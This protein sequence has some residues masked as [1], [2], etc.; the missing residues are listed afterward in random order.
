[1]FI[2]RL[3]I[4]TV[5]IINVVIGKTRFTISPCCPLFTDIFRTVSDLVLLGIPIAVQRITLESIICI[6]FE[7]IT[8]KAELS[9]EGRLY[10]QTFTIAFTA[11]NHLCGNDTCRRIGPC[12]I[13]VLIKRSWKNIVDIGQTHLRRRKPTCTSDHCIVTK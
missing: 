1:M 3:Q 11:I 4:S 10:I 7:F 8:K 12:S 13:R 2:K 6:Y 5:N 9:I